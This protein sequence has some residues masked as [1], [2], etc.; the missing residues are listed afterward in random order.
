[1]GFEVPKDIFWGLRYPLTWSNKFS[2]GMG[3]LG[4][5]VEKGKGPW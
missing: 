4:A 2:A 3:K 5:M 1:M